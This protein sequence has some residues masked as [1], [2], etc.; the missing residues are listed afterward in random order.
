MY[1]LIQHAAAVYELAVLMQMRCN[2]SLLG[3]TRSIDLR[4]R[5]SWMRIEV[6]GP[7]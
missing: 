7:W 5:N 4:I 3:F 1:E 2:R 6:V